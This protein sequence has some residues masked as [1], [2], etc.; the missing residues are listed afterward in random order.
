MNKEKTLEELYEMRNNLLAAYVI[1]KDE[2]Q[3]E[4]LEKVNKEIKK[5]MFM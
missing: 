5:K 2:Y 3:V 1:Q 4:Q